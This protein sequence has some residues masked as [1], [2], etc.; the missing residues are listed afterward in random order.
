MPLVQC[1][2]LET[3]Y[4]APWGLPT[5]SADQLVL[6]VHGA[7]GSSRHWEPMLKAWFEKSLPNRVFLVAI[8]LPGHG[9]SGGTVLSSVS[10]IADFLNTFLDTLEIH[11]PVCLVGHSAGGLLGLQFTLSYP[12]RVD[13]LML[14]ATSACIQL[15]PDFLHQAVTQ[16]WDYVTLEQS[17]SPEIPEAL[18]QLVLKE[19]Q[20]LRL[21]PDADDFMDLNQVDLRPALSQLTLPITI[22]TGDDDVIISPRK[23]KLLQ[24]ELPHAELVIVPGGGHYVQV[25]QAAAIATV[26]TNFLQ[27]ASLIQC[28]T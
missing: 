25:E 11:Q 23:S 15:H 18:K 2:G 27:S 26:L 6:L 7:G 13:R 20:H 21:S 14:I 9:N 10:A 19:F 16:N 28:P 4:L 5:S 24:K 22:V 8:D 1:N 17:F 3:H 12:Q